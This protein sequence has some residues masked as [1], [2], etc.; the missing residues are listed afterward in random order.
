[1]SMDLDD[2]TDIRDICRLFWYI[3]GCSLDLY[4][5]INPSFC[6]VSSR[7]TVLYPIHLSHRTDRY[8]DATT[9]KQYAA[10]CNTRRL[11]S[12]V[13]FSPMMGSPLATRQPWPAL[14]V[15]N[16]TDFTRVAVRREGNN[17]E[18]DDSAGIFDNDTFIVC[19][20][21]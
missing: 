6:L 14:T 9:Q 7:L 16:F 1:M 21:Q 8:F 12:S 18:A 15:D 17:N 20:H 2:D 5:A 11:S 13:I 3:R 19:S 10:P 4:D